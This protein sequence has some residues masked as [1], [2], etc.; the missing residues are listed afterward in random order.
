MKKREVFML[1]ALAVTLILLASYLYSFTI[2]D[3]EAIYLTPGVLYG[4]EGWEIFT[5]ENGERTALDTSEVR[6]SKGTVYLERVIEAD[7]F[8][9]GCSRVKL[10]GNR[11]TSIFVDGALVFTNCP[12]AG[13]VIP[14]SFPH[15]S[16][17]PEVISNP[18]FTLDSAW[19]GMTL[20]VATSVRS[21]RAGMPTF[22]I[23]SD[24]VEVAQ[25]NAFSNQ[26]I[27]PA[28]LFSVIGFLLLGLFA[29]SLIMRQTDFGLLLLSAAA[30]MQM[31][32]AMLIVDENALALPLQ[33]LFSH[34][35]LLFPM[36]YIALRMKKNRRAYLTTLL[37]CWGISFALIAFSY[38]LPVPLWLLTLAPYLLLI[39]MAALFPIGISEK[40]SGNN[41]M[42]SFMPWLFTAAGLLG[43][44][45]LLSFLVTALIPEREGL[46]KW[47][48]NVSFYTVL[49]GIPIFLLQGF[50]TTLLVLIFITALIGQIRQG[51]QSAEDAKLLTLKNDLI[52][53]NLHALENTSKALAVARHDELFHLHTISKL[54][55]ESPEQAAAYADSLTAELTNIPPVGFYTGNRI[56]NT[57]LT[58]QAG[59]AAANSVDY[60]A[61]AIVPESL[62]IPDKDICTVLMN[63][64]DNAITAASKAAPE[65]PRT[66]SV[67]LFVEESYLLI[68][69]ENTLPADFNPEAFRETLEKK[70]RSAADSHGFGLI[71]ARTTLAR[72]GGE[73]RFSI[74]GDE[75]VLQTAMRLK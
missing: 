73:L 50:S 38:W 4:A 2:T 64:I 12:A 15:E 1:S 39:P 25:S 60:R 27:I 43:V 5:L 6:D 36:L 52:L 70:A 7:W 16:E 21:E 26:R 62:P 8:T 33:P 75:L 46:F 42:R 31:F 45:L 44:L 14:V 56:I 74:R 30:F 10:S 69:I 40:R 72:Y 66:V 54:Y 18:Q 17:K 34:C 67:R 55:R 3:R 19:I 37:C 9:Y 59:K 68:V 20:T 13:A 53:E 11:F 63:L 28:T 29:Y 41:A 49:D 58:V 71:S 57:I 65:K 35:F 22:I 48:I 61:E 51:I 47:F 23:T 32:S 24:D